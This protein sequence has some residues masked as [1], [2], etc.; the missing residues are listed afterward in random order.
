MREKRDVLTG[1]LLGPD[2]R[3]AADSADELVLELRDVRAGR[4]IGGVLLVSLGALALGLLIALA[5]PPESR[6]IGWPIS[7]LLFLVA[8]LGLP[9]AV[10]NLQ[11]SRLG[12]RLRITPTSVEGW[13]VKLSFKPRS[14]PAADVERVAVSVYPHPPLSL[15]LFEVVL[16]D[17]TRLTGPEVAVP[18]GE[19]HPLGPV[20]RAAL[21]L[22]GR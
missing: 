9:A 20:E 5:C 13:P 12:V 11:R 15:A 3:V 17:G 6:L 22:L 7:L 8:G 4:R 1:R 19:E 18:S 16:R 2:W 21:A 10:R 14:A